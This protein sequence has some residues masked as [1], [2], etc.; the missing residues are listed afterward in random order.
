MPMMQSPQQ[1]LYQS[2][3]TLRFNLRWVLVVPFLLQ[4]SAAVGLTSYL[5]IRNGQ[6]AV[7][8]VAS[9]LRSE[10][11]A[12]VDRYLATYLSRP[13]EINQLNAN[14]LSLGLLDAQNVATLQRH[15]WNQSRSLGQQTPL[16]IFF[17]NSRGG[18]V[19]TGLYSLGD[20]PFT[21]YTLDFQAGDLYSYFLDPVGNVSSEPNGN[22][23]AVKNYD[24]RKRPWYREAVASR[25]QVW[26]DVYLYVNG[27]L[28]ITASQP[29]IDRTGQ[30][31][32]V[33]AV[34]FTLAGITEFLRTIKIGE[35]GLVFVVDRQGLMIASSANEPPY[36][37][38]AN[39]EE[40]QRLRANQS[41]NPLISN[42][43]SY[44][45][46]RFGNL[47]AINQ[48]QQL[49]FTLNNQKQF[50]QVSPFRDP[51]GI[52]WLIITA[53][54]EATFMAEIHENTRTTIF[55]CLLALVIAAAS[56][57]YTSRW[58][59]RPVSR[60]N[61]ASAAIARGN[62]DQHIQPESIEELD[63]LGQTFNEMSRQLKAAF[64]F[65]E[66]TNTELENRV[67]ERTIELQIAKQAADAANQAKSEFLANMSHELRTPL[68]GILGYAQVLQ[69]HERL[70]DKQSQ[71]LRVI[72]QCG[73]HLLNL[74][75]DV[76]DLAKI[77]AR[78]LE[79][80]PTEF[81]LS[82]FLLGVVDICRIRAEQKGIEFVYHTSHELPGIVRADEKR[83]RQVLINL[84]GNAIKFTDTGTVTLAV[85]SLPG[86]RVRFSIADTGVGMSPEQLQKIFQPFEQVGDQK[87]R[88]EGTG[89]G[90]AISQ[91]II[92]L[93]GSE[94]Q[95]SSH[96]GAG[97]T[98]WFELSLPVATLPTVTNQPTGEIIGYQGS[99]RHILVVDDYQEN[100]D[101]LTEMLENIGFVVSQAGHGQMALEMLQE[102]SF[103]LAIVDLVMPV[104]DGQ[105]LIKCIREQSQFQGLK[106]IVSS[107]SVSPEDRQRS[108]DAGGNDF[109][110]KPVIEA[111]LHEILQKHLGLEW[112]RS[113]T[114]PNSS[115]ELV[116]PPPKVTDHLYELAK[117]GLMS[118]IQEQLQQLDAEYSTFAQQALTLVQTF[119]LRALREFLEQA[120]R[121]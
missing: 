7:N 35:Q 24:A 13:H 43:A 82:S 25:R 32:G 3:P 19:G 10:V 79:L 8:N 28:G 119:Q 80:Q 99:R 109:L 112:V 92:R 14:S 73:L 71:G 47:K 83:L 17:G 107:A 74:I 93:M 64:T 81:A 96:E 58:I 33:A 97:S 61:L 108:L 60:L 53:V 37:K 20:R 6:R 54:P 34:D 49:E 104:M 18:F 90:L 55:L 94:I 31:L 75:N 72:H 106:I 121:L 118:Q 42:T 62:L 21:D 63:H 76:L 86:D 102:H 38:S 57:F 1:Q 23:P 46:S 5:S 98:F 9:Q 26:T 91:Q 95:V 68:N 40:P 52:D 30:F 12:R 111:Q 29:V 100:R 78:R 117:K 50:V 84:L 114:I 56:G 101:V 65:L 22:V 77:E 11:T 59:L 89:L 85:E 69:H 15:F 27:S 120:R 88:A 113:D 44:L 110:D 70:D 87:K 48:T 41:I 2:S 45:E 105:S 16:F 36:L 51:H 67:Q 4:V 103:D 39:N 116:I 115:A 66:N